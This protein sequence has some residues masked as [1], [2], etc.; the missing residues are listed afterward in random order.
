MTH[1]TPSRGAAMRDGERGAGS[2]LVVAILSVAVL[3]LALVIPLYKGL[4]L[5]RVAAGAAD[6]SA[7]AAADVAVGIVPGDPCSV[8]QTVAAANG[9]E[10]ARCEVDGLVATVLI[11]V[12]RDGFVVVSGATA[13]PAPRPQLAGTK[14]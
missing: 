10:L 12:A 3:S 9:A 4:V 14:G 8:A 5:N 2:V 1:A 11:T 13:G 6:A 7:L